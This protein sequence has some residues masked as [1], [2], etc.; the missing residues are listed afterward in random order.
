MWELPFGTN[1]FGIKSKESYAAIT[2]ARKKLVCLTCSHRGCTHTL[3]ANE[4][5]QGDSI[6]VSLNVVRLAA[7]VVSS[8]CAFT[9]E[10]PPQPLSRK[11]RTSSAKAK[12]H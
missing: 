9:A 7:L 1:W 2:V 10:P 5:L 4:L 6:E 3:Y 12:P 11:S 8:N